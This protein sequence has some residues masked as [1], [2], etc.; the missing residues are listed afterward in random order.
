MKSLTIFLTLILLVF[1]LSSCTPKE[2][3]IDD[4]P[5]P[6]DCEQNPSHEDCLIDIPEG[7]DY[8]VLFAGDWNKPGLHDK[9][10]QVHEMPR[11]I[12]KTGITLDVTHFGATPN[13]PTF[14]NYQAFKDAIDQAIPGDEV[15]VPE[16]MYYFTGSRP[17]EGYYSHI[18]LK[19]GILFTG[20]GEDKTTLVS[21][22]SESSNQNRETS[23]IT[24]VNASDILITNMTL[25]SD[26]PDSVLPDP[27]NSGLQSNVFTG[28]KYG[29]TIDSPRTVTSSEQQAHNV[30]I[31][32]VTIEKFQRMG[33]RIR[34]SREI[35]IDDVTFKNALNLGGGGAGY[36]IS[37]QG[38]GFNTNWTDSLKDTVFNIVKNAHFEGPYLRH[39][40]IVQYFAHNNL[41]EHNHF[42]N[43]LL[44][45]I[46]M[47]GEDEYSNEIRYNTIINTRQGAG[48]GVGN[49]GATHDASGRNNFIHNNVIDGGLRGIDVIL[50]SPRTIIVSN[51]IKNLNLD[52]S[53][54]ITLSKS[55]YTYVFNNTFENI[56]GSTGGYGIKIT[57]SYN[58]IEP[59]DGI[60]NHIFI[61]YNTFKAVHKGIYVETYGDEFVVSD[62]TFTE[63]GSYDFLS[64]KDTFYVPPK[65]E[66]M[67]PVIGYELLPT[68][69]NFITTEDPNGVQSQKN[70]KFKSSL[71]EPTYNRMIYAK[72]DLSEVLT[73]YTKVYLSISAKAQVGMPTINIW[74]ST[75][76]TDWSTSTIT[77]NNSRLH[78]P[79]IAKTWYNPEVD[80]LTKI[81]DFTFPIAAYEFNT[82]YIDVTDYFIHELDQD[83]FTMVLSNDDIE[84]VYME[85]YNH[86]QTA[87][88]QHFRLIFTNGG[89][90]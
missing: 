20:A 30:V 90:S 24:M 50:G 71:S 37:I 70:M 67:V 1:M 43:I 26:T 7:K 74:G 61:R 36:G 79:S 12:T 10:G 5:D 44:D 23:L 83:V 68:D 41:I 66:L 18:E 35:V 84:E 14:N 53:I 34:L 40:I 22:F 58:P 16:G 77:W 80:N 81:V 51:V 89:T 62:N 54:G 73:T 60:P 29:I 64:D 72:F 52:R 32:S 15:F 4:I 33:V 46:D 85:V 25:T 78:E 8:E 75:S 86:L 42:E 21:K 39:G 57:Y 38:S 56:T 69:V 48:I 45:A 28:P 6:I 63:S 76:F 9:S 59:S 27:N 2:N 17:V 47:H 88:N 13:D 82:Y 49:S 19:S 55:P 3:P 31:K 87:S 65:S 11:E